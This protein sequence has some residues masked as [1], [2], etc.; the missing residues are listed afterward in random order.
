MIDQ[1][2]FK[3]VVGQELKAVC[4]QLRISESAYERVMK[5][6][7]ATSETSLETLKAALQH[8]D[9]DGVQRIGHELKGVF[10]NMRINALSGMAADIDQIARN[11]KPLD[12][13]APLVAALVEGF[14][15]LKAVFTA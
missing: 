8:S 15:K 13:A 5:I 4:E 6:T 2:K 11:G 3:E 7:M 12:E 10:G 1:V 9:R 14:G